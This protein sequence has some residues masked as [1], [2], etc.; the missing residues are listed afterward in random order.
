MS[1]LPSSRPLAPEPTWAVAHLFPPQGEWTENEFFALHG[2]RLIELVDGN[3]EV[4]PMPTWLHQLIVKFLVRAVESASGGFGEVLDA[5]LPIRLFEQNIREPDVMYF[6]PG[7]EPQDPRGYPSRVD[8]A[9]EVVSEGVEAA[10]R[11][12]E[13]KRRDY[14][15]AGIPEYWIVDPEQERVTVL[16]LDEN[17]YRVHGEFR[18]GDTASSVLL[19]ALM[20]DVSQ[21]MQLGTSR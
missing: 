17:A 12:Y 8:L 19:P 1:S 18:P 7:S 6:A 16:V 15:R 21:V 3:L 2:N 11:D 4:L 5:P 20:I 9:M 14:A 10:R 13:D